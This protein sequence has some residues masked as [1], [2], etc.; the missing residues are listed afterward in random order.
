[1]VVRPEVL[2]IIQARGNSKGVPRKNLR[3]LGGHPLIAYSI[4][5]GLA[6]ETVTRLIIS[7]DD[8]EIVD[9]SRQ[10]G[11]EVPFL[12]PS[13]LATDDA[14]DFPLFEHALQ[15]LDTNEGYRPQVIIQLRPTT[16]FRPRGLIDEAIRLLLEDPE[17]DCVRGVTKSTQNPYKMWRI[18]KDGYLV[19]LLESEFPEPYNMPRQELPPT[20]WQTGHIDVIRYETIM[21]KHSLT[22]NRVRP[23]LVDRS[24]CIDIDT[25]YDFDLANWILKQGFLDIDFPQT[26]SKR[27][28][29][30]T[31]AL[32]VFDF[33]GVFTDNRVWLTEDGRETVA[34]HRGDGMG[35]RL[36][37]RQGIK[38]AV[39]ST[40]SN[41]VVTTRCQKLDLPCY[42]A[43]EDKAAVLSSLA[44]K[45]QADLK[46]MIYVGNDV[47]DLE[48]MRLAGYAVA[49]ADAHPTVL[50]QAD[51]VLQ[52]RGG[53]GA[54]RELCDL[55]IKSMSIRRKYEKSN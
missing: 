16:P 29:P 7:T 12:R 20:Y 24:Y 38:I 49:V 13:A 35:V 44:Q 36:L 52:N 33:D 41:P 34:C 45:E 31:V 11:A 46:D 14:P 39:L 51:L 1:M 42:Q 4:A 3:M 2:A 5:S 6:A 27:S 28:W 22:G 43:L 50:A 55:I 18:E 9:V 8:E 30:Q 25:P 19:P 54:V 15:W 17:A 37:R 10:Y 53:Y 32:L 40:E 48:C 23:I 26:R 47:N 21:N